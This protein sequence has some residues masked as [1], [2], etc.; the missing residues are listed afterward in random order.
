MCPHSG[1][2]PLE[3]AGLA[4]AVPEVQLDVSPLGLDRHP[5]PRSARRARRRRAARSGGESLPR[6]AAPV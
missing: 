1:Q 5:V 2:V 4:W 6:E 3:E